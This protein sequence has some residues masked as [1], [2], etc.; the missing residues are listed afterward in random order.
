MESLELISEDLLFLLKELDL[1]LLQCLVLKLILNGSQSIVDLDLTLCLV[2]DLSLL[3]LW[4]FI[5]VL[6]PELGQENAH[7][8]VIADL[9]AIEKELKHL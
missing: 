3:C 6:H 4:V 7:V 8:E 9:L 1:L 5:L 2:F